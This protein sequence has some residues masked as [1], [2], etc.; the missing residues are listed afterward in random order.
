MADLKRV[1]E[2]VADLKAWKLAFENLREAS[3]STRP[4]N[5]LINE[6][7]LFIYR[8]K[9]I[10]SMDKFKDDFENK[11]EDFIRDVEAF[12]QKAYQ[13]IS[14]LATRFGGK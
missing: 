7:K 13:R 8:A 3:N 9:F 12:E 6:V 11:I 10:N 14:K 5:G 2:K 1:K 4:F